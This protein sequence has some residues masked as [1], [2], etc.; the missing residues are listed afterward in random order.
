MEGLISVSH[1]LNFHIILIPVGLALARIMFKDLE[2]TSMSF[3]KKLA[4]V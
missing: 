2:F 1:L 3:S 4:I